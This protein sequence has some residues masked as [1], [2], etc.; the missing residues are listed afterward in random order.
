[1]KAD[2]ELSDENEMGRIRLFK[3]LL[4]QLRVGFSGG[5]ALPTARAKNGM[6]GAIEV[7]VPVGRIRNEK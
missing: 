4:S 7:E 5:T 3:Q 6:D 2:Q 1:V